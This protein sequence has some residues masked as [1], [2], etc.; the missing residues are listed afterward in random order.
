MDLFLFCYEM[1]FVMS[2]SNNKQA[3]IIAAFNTK[4]RYL[5]DILNINNYLF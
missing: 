4:S 1:D 5:N 2:L 3:N